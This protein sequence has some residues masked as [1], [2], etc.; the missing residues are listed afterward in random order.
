MA[1][2]HTS[3]V[4]AHLLHAALAGDAAGLTDGQLLER[5]VSTAFRKFGGSL[6]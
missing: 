5:F 1:A 2:S 6:S 4:I 3:E